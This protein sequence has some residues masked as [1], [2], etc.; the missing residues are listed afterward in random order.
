MFAV[1]SISAL[2][3]SIALLAGGIAGTVP[4]SAEIHGIWFEGIPGDGPAQAAIVLP[5]GPE[6]LAEP[7]PV[8]AGFSPRTR[9]LTSVPPTGIYHSLVR[10]ATASPRRVHVLNC[11]FII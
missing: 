9:D 2:I 7:T 8:S 11:V 10:T 6:V 1:R 3:L 4:S 5:T